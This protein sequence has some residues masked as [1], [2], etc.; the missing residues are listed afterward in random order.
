MILVNSDSQSA[1]KAIQNA[2]F[3]AR[4]K[5]FDMRHHF[6]RDEVA[7]GEIS[8]GIVTGEDNPADI[9]T[10]NL[11]WVKYARALQLLRMT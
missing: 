2:I 9:F 6:I 3:H 11:D 4:T 7:K 5:H 8:T 10:K 1:S